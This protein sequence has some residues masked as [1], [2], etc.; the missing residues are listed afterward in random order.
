MACD[1]AAAAAVSDDDND[2]KS[3]YCYRRTRHDSD[4]DIVFWYC[5]VLSP[6]LLPGSRNSLNLSLRL[7]PTFGHVGQ[8]RNPSSFIAGHWR[9]WEEQYIT[10]KLSS[11]KINPYPVSTDDIFHLFWSTHATNLYNIHIFKEM[12]LSYYKRMSCEWSVAECDRHSAS[13]RGWSWGRGFKSWPGHRSDNQ[14]VHL[15]WNINW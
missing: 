1:A 10:P 4:T 12:F 3:E 7:G 2:D 5:R 8:G 15:P 13:R 6:S 11:H 9:H 14:A